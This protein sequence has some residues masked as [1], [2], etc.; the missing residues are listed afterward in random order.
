MPSTRRTSSR[1]S[2][3]EA[4]SM[5]TT[6]VIV[7]MT[8]FRYG[9]ASSFRS[10][11][12]RHSSLLRELDS[13]LDNLTVVPH[14]ERHPANPEW[15]EELRWD[16]VFDVLG[17]DTFSGRTLPH[18]L[19][20]D[21]LHLFI[22]SLEFTNENDGDF[23]GMVGCVFGVHERNDEADGL[24]EGSAEATTENARAIVLRTYSSA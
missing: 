6:F 22:R 14:I 4:P 2:I 1:S 23:L 11:D 7:S 17:S 20:H 5:A 12:L 8:I 18:H 21:L 15:L 24:Q 19:E 10:D 13:S 16:V 3:S 9:S